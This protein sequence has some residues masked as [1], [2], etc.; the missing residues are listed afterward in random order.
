MGGDLL[1]NMYA[2]LQVDPIERDRKISGAEGLEKL[3]FG[4][5]G[6]KAE[7]QH[8]SRCAN[9]KNLGAPCVW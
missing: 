6:K 3:Q 8:A 1:R 5:C 2:K 4:K 7:T 9:E